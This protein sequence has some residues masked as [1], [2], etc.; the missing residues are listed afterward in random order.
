MIHLDLLDVA[1]LGLIVL[2]SA[3]VVPRLA[4]WLFRKHAEFKKACDDF[5]R[6]L[7]R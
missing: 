2:F 3:T 6:N 5:E 1:V 4:A 7:Y